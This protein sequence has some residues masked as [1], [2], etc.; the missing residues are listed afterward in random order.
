MKKNL[1]GTLAVVNFVSFFVGCL[2]LGG[3]ALNGKIEDG[4]FY[5][6]DH[7]KLTE[8]SKGIYRYSQVHGASV[9]ALIGLTLIVHFAQKTD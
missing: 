3:D 8:V 9:F 6:S 1:L 4:H 2:Y 5:L 7:G